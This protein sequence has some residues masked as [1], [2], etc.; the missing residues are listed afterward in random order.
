MLNAL[1]GSCSRI[2]YH[3]ISFICEPHRSNNFSACTKNL[4]KK[5]TVALG[6]FMDRCIML[7]W[8]GEKMAWRE[9][10]DITN[11]NDIFIFIMSFCR[12]LFGDDFAENAGIH[13]FFSWWMVY[14][15][16]FE[17]YVPEI[18]RDLQEKPVKMPEEQ[19][20]IEDLKTDNIPARYSLDEI[21]LCSSYVG[22]PHMQS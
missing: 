3:P 2:D 12:Y 10:V 14:N 15:R 8:N 7:F 17:H 13:S 18:S 4:S 6:Y 19:S 11:D 5:S 20:S 21:A 22:V 1:P 16:F 9:R